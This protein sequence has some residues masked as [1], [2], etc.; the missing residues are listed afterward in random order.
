MFVLI[1]SIN[2]TN[3]IN[4]CNTSLGKDAMNRVCTNG[5]FVA[6][7]FPIGI[8]SNWYKFYQLIFDDNGEVFS[9][10]NIENTWLKNAIA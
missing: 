5:L 4:D 3:S 7:F 2:N 6:L 1:K 9:L 10:L 8:F